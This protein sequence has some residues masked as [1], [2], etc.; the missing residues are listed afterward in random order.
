LLTG[1][2]FI[3]EPIIKIENVGKRYNIGTKRKK[4]D[5]FGEVI[6]DVLKAPLRRIKDLRGSSYNHDNDFWA[7][8]NIT[9]N[10]EP[11]DVVGIVGRNGSGKS[12][13]LKILSKITNPTEGRALINGRVSSLL[14]VGTG[15]HP[16][17]TGR[18][19]IFLNGAI[20]GM[21]QSEIKDKFDEIVAFAEVEKFL[22]TPVKRYSSG[23]YVRLAFAV[24]AHLEPEILIVDEVL[25][26][27]D[28]KFQKKC[29]GKMENIS[30]GGRT[31]L[32]VSHNMGA[33]RSL[34]NKGVLLEDGN[35]KV[36]GAS[37]DVVDQYM[38]SLSSKDD[39][40]VVKNMKRSQLDLPRNIQITNVQI[41][42]KT[43]GCINEAETQDE[44]VIKI[45]YEILDEIEYFSAEFMFRDI[46]GA[47]L[48][49]SSSAPMGKTVFY[50]DKNKKFGSI[51][52]R[53]PNFPL[54]IGEYVLEVG[55]AI[56]GVKYFD[57][58]SD[59]CRLTIRASDPM[60]TGYQ[61]K[62][63]FAPFY[64]D[65]IWETASFKK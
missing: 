19:N 20:L 65:S 35:C 51:Q 9:F 3:M 56:P 53:I 16:D 21:G 36:T 62:R 33:V 13:L 55:L 7:L 49:Y 46:Y 59:V 50:P 27:G 31:I 38:R 6:V 57:Q 44:V 4:H 24:A 14:E 61:L 34:C 54:S 8:K 47:N 26:V 25:A 11:G 22:D 52:C 2:A 32:F 30:K 58:I 12:T 23:M 29:M 28:I 42:D 60:G 17:L 40:M 18:E 15:F 64:A 10:V 41:E 1:A 39:N 63:E 48:F 45:D 43:I 5:T 37:N